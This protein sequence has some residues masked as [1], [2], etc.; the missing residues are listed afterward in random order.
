MQVIILELK[1]IL[2]ENIQS[3]IYLFSIFEFS[4]LFHLKSWS[5]ISGF[6]CL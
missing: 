1:L 3:R 2:N 5:L 4:K 6:W